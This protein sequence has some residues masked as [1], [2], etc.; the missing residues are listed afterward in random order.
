[1]DLLQIALECIYY[2]NSSTMSMVLRVKT[3]T[4][5]PDAQEPFDAQLRK[6]IQGLTV[7]DIKYS[8]STVPGDTLYVM[9]SALIM[10]DA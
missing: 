1:M 6:E 10:Y 3:V 2:Q 4:V 7:K 8:A 9:Q 5:G